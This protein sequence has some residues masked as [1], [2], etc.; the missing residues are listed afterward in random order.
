M[1]Q[2]FVVFI[3]PD[4]IVC[5]PWREALKTCV[6][7][8]DKFIIL[9]VI[10]SIHLTESTSPQKLQDLVSLTQ[11]RPTF[12]KGTILFFLTNLQPLFVCFDWFL[13]DFPL[14]LLFLQA[15]L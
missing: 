8:G 9:Q 10:G 1:V 3:L 11:K 7:D 12:A 6:F 5:C 2:F 13:Y 15:L 4:N 14:R